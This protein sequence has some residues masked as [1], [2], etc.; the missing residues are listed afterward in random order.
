[1][2]AKLNADGVEFH[3]F[4]V[5]LRIDMKVVGFSFVKNAVRFDYPIV[6]AI[7]SILPICDRFVVAVGDCDD[8]TRELIESIG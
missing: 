6:E 8:G 2:S 4:V 5:S 3:C 1:M 7:K